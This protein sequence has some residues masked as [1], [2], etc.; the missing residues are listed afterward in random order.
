MAPRGVGGGAGRGR[1]DRGL[2]IGA[3]VAVAL[4]V[5][6]C[7]YLTSLAL[8]PNAPGFSFDP[9]DPAF[10]F[11]PNDPAF[12]FDPEGSGD[13]PKAT[14]T[15]GTATLT[16]GTDVITL[17]R[18]VGIGSLSDAYGGQASWT[19]GTGWYVQA[20]GVSPGGSPFGEDAFVSFDRIVDGQ[21][22]T[23]GDPSSCQIT[24]TA[25]DESRLAGSATCSGLRW[26]DLMAGYGSPDGPV[27]VA[28]QPAF[29]A[30][31]TFEAT[32]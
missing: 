8:G 15:H 1:R 20:F 24:V 9:N 5:G 17:D 11:D 32:P 14:Y 25:A 23:V 30:T 28:G 2:V 10:S 27:Y 29:D 13:I 12:S 4:L 26:A 16:I 31:V 18:I 22:W 21:H 3:L 6:G 19:D 7:D